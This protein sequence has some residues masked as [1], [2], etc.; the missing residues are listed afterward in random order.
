VAR[1]RV[2]LGRREDLGADCAECFGLCCVALAFSR[3]SDFPFDKAAGDPCVNLD[4]PDRCRV[5]ES[6]RPRGFVG[7]TVFDCFGAG[8]KVSKT[9]F[10]GRSWRDDPDV[11]AEMFAVFPIMRRVHELLWYL[12][13]AIALPGAHSVREELRAQFDAVLALSDSS[14]EALLSADVDA[15]Y[16]AARPALIA[17]S[18]AA[19]ASARPRPRS[20]APVTVGG[21]ALRAG[22]DLAG[23]DLRGADLRG[24]DLRGALLIGADL[25]GT[26]LFRCDLLGVDLRGADLSGARLEQAIYLS[27]MQVNGAR[28]DTRTTLPAGFERPSHWSAPGR[29]AQASAPSKLGADPRAPSGSVRRLGL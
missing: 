7:C 17:A 9:T 14:P 21:R 20:A 28:G 3:S 10:E 12:D 25:T 26:D 23:A 18:E 19:R 13:S 1:T 6:L 27:Q 15:F 8:Q 24:A 5:H 2:E 16:A 11:R 4:P 22:S 29:R